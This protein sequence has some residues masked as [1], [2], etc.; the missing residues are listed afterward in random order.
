MEVKKDIEQEP[1]IRQH[2]GVFGEKIFDSHC[3][4]VI[5]WGYTP[6]SHLGEILFQA[7]GEYGSWVCCYPSW[8]L[9]TK[10]LTPEAAIEKYGK[11]TKVVTGI[12]GGWRKAIYG[13]KVF[14]S[15]RLDPR[16]IIDVPENLI[17]IDK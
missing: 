11:L 15:E 1:S 8:Y 5:G 4:E 16:G 3:G 6:T 9:I 10:F 17:E 13:E 2:F 7:C 12:R 14:S